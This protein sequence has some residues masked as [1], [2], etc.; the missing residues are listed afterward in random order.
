[1]NTES[2]NTQLRQIVAASELSQPDFLAK[3]NVGQMCPLSLSAFKSYLTSEAA[4]RYA[5][6]PDLVLEHAR[7]LI[8]QM[9]KTPLQK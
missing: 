6:C 4:S 8:W 7:K 1:M 2:N 5:P 9:G 3:L